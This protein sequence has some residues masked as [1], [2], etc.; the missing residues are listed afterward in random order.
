M[1]PQLSPFRVEQ[2]SDP[3]VMADRLTEVVRTINQVRG[4]YRVIRLQPVQDGVDIVLRP[5]FVVDAAV[6]GQISTLDGSAAPT[7]APFV[8]TLL[9]QQDGTCLIRLTG[10]TANVRYVVTLMLFEN[11]EGTS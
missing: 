5:G 9:T 3:E 4:R 8:S 11:T 7:V 1:R 2:T 10:L 6:I